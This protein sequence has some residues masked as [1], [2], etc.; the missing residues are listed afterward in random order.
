MYILHLSPSLP[1]SLPPLHSPHPPSPNPPPSPRRR[2]PTEQQTRT[3]PHLPPRED[4]RSHQRKM[5]LWDGGVDG[6]TD[7]GGVGS[8]Q[9]SGRQRAWSWWQELGIWWPSCELLGLGLGVLVA[10]AGTWGARRWRRGM[11]QGLI[12]DYHGS[13]LSWDLGC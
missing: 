11:G 13:C 3:V 6:R 4:K 12:S 2:R 9:L 8:H 1:P 7:E 10:W 5:V